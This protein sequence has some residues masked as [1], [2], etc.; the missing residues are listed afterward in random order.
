MTRARHGPVVTGVGVLGGAASTF[1]AWA[2]ALFADGAAVGALARVAPGFD[3]AGRLGPRGLRYLDRATRWALAAAAECLAQAGLDDERPADRERL[4]VVAACGLGTIDTVQRIVTT[5]HRDGTVALSPMDT[6]NASPNVVGAQCAIRFALRGPILC[7]ANGFATGLEAIALATRCVRLGRADAM[8]VVGVESLEPAAAA[9]LTA[10]ATGS[11]DGLVPG[12]GAV[13]LLLETPESAAGRGAR[14]LARIAGYGLGRCDDDEEG[15]GRGLRAAADGA[16]AACGTDGIDLL[17]SADGGATGQ[18]T[19][20]RAAFRGT[21]LAAVPRVVPK[22]RCGDAY[23]AG[24]LF[25]AAAGLACLERQAV[26]ATPAGWPAR[27]GVVETRR[28]ALALHRALVVALA[29]DE[30]CA[31]VVLERG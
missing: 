9:V 2:D 14:V 24:G 7:L 11:L 27:D 18:A 23:C 25:E 15:G 10:G 20:E 17:V 19:I 8:L 30:P 13:A 29:P 28:R 1:A 5:I 31:A 12:E 21:A 4:G 6:P 22:A 3:P 26:F 16:I